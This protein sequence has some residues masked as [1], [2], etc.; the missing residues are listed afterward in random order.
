MFHYS[1]KAIWR[2]YRIPLILVVIFVFLLLS[3]KNFSVFSSFKTE[4]ICSTS[5]L[6]GAVLCALT[7]GGLVCVS[8]KT[9][10]GEENGDNATECISALDCNLSCN[11]S[12]TLSFS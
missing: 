2:R 5:C 3:D 1:F 12:I 8:T 11:V 10:D 9:L 6:S 4:D 7:W